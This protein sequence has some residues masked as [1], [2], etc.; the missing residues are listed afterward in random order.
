L[1]YSYYSC[2]T[3]N[4]NEVQPFA[5]VQPVPF[6][7]YAYVP[8]QE[9]WKPT[10]L[11]TLV[12]LVPDPEGA[13]EYRFSRS[14]GERPEHNVLEFH[15]PDSSPVTRSCRC[16]EGGNMVYAV[17]SRYSRGEQAITRLKALLKALSD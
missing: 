6:D 14:A 16:G 1:R 11:I 5:H 13:V 4:R 10:D 2:V 12:W 8:Y 9:S 3:R 17:R 7:G 15:V